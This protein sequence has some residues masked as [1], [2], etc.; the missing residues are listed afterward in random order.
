[1]LILILFFVPINIYISFKLHFV[2]STN[3]FY[4]I[5]IVGI[6]QTYR[7]SWYWFFCLCPV[8]YME[9]C[10]II[11]SKSWMKYCACW[12]CDNM[13]LGV[14]IPIPISVHLHITTILC[15]NNQFASS[16]NFSLNYCVI[17]KCICFWCEHDKIKSICC[18]ISVCEWHHIFL[19]Q[20]MSP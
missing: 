19:V 2:S 4:D 17:L 7:I 14:L 3:L 5:I 15:F 12:K 10:Y 8:I 13:M 11:N 1:M 18:F 6:S 9:I 20:L 16:N